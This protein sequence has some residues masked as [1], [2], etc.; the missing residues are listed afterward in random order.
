MHLHYQ[1]RTHA[2]SQRSLLEDASRMGVSFR[3]FMLHL[4]VQHYH[5]EKLQ[6][7][8]GLQLMFLVSRGEDGHTDLLQM[9][10]ISKATTAVSPSEGLL[11]W[12]SRQISHNCPKPTSEAT[13]TN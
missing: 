13:I 1:L 2:R 6:I 10:V 11:H 3:T 5:W 7:T 4:K 12:N 9:A 8:E